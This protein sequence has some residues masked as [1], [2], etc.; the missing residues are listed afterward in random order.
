MLELIAQGKTSTDRWRKILLT[1]IPFVL[2]RTS[3]D[4]AVSWDEKVSRNHALL[5]LDKS[6][7]HIEKIKEAANPIFFKGGESEDFQVQPGEPVSYTHLTLPT[8]A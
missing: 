3:K 6:V 8:K 4:W 1:G 5:R 2:G 7:L